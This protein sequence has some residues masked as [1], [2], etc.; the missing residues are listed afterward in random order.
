MKYEK[1][2][3]LDKTIINNNYLSVLDEI[4][5]PFLLLKI[6]DLT[7][8]MRTKNCLKHVKIFRIIDLVTKTKKSVS[9]IP[10][11]GSHSVN[12]IIV[13]LESLNLTLDMKFESW[14]PENYVQICQY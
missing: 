7:L 14:P 5:N 11:L 4:P 2:K 1:D 10:N 9:K 13:F 3:Y 12:E 8:S 6:D